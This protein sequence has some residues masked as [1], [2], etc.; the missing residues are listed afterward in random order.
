MSF[1]NQ[2]QI[3][4]NHEKRGIELYKAAFERLKNN[5]PIRLP[6]GAVVSQ[7]NVA[8]EA[9]KDPSALR[10]SRFPSLIA[11]IQKYIEEQKNISSKSVYQIKLLARR[12][13]RSFK[14]RLEEIIKQRDHL[15]SLLVEADETILELYNQVSAL[16]RKVSILNVA[17][18]GKNLSE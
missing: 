11:E 3:E 9:G 16:E 6:K 17:I 2:S 10:K 8:K 4:L 15:A 1:S 12:K 5:K 13:N 7:N 18:E 14:E